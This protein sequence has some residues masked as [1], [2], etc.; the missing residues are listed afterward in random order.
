MN[1]IFD[2]PIDKIISSRISVRT[3]SDQSVQQEQIVKIKDFINKLSNPFKIKVKFTILKSDETKTAKL[4]TYGVI[5]G[6]KNYIGATVING[7][8]ALEALGYEFEKLILY[9]TSLGLGTC[10][11]GGTFKRGEFA[12]AM[13]INEDELFPIISP[14]GYAAD[15]KSFADSLV[16]FMAKGNS[17]K[18][19][20]DLFFNE[21]FS[22]PLSLSQ[23]GA[24]QRALEMVRVAPSASNKQPWRIIKDKKMYHFY[25]NKSPGYSKAFGYDIQRI[26]MG[27]AACHF[28][29]SA[30][31][32][33]LIGEYKK[34]SNPLTDVPNGNHYV[35]SWIPE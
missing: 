18:P 3:Y 11:L 14:F 2:Y 24:Y 28:H 21:S 20:S 15:K 27:I 22:T 1:T 13:S 10:W 31:E 29:L 26:D 25:E 34:I 35:F 30:A 19:W 17:R 9:L 7:D 6:A 8:F 4:G 33:G 12:R 16:R 32:K 5:K 23:A